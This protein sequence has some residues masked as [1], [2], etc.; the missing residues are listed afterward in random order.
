MVGPNYSSINIDIT[1][2]CALRCSR[3]ARLSSPWFLKNTKEI[4]IDNF[5]K[6]TKV[7]SHV[8]F[9][10]QTSDP[11]YHRDFEGIL[12]QCVGK[13]VNI[14]TAGHGR[15]NDW[16]DNITEVALYT[17]SVRFIFALD[18]LPKDSHKY[19][20]GQDGE[21]V[22]EVMKRVNRAFKQF[23]H[24]TVEWQYIVFNYNENDVEEAKEMALAEGIRFLMVKSNRWNG[25]NDPLMPNNPNMYH[26]NG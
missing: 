16:W 11:I 22:W 8:N 15:S 26:Y 4:S 24:A 21:R 1:N 23:K 13:H 9:C 12:E 18:G 20:V 2:K 3:C 17:K 6:I 7:V 14:H 19:R 25:P 5:A 10:G